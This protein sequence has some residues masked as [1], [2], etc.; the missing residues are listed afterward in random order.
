[1]SADLIPFPKW[2]QGK[3]LYICT[4]CKNPFQWREGESTWYGK[5]DDSIN[6]MQAIICS[7]K[8]RMEWAEING[9]PITPDPLES[10]P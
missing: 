1:M 6:E 9:T 7:Q 2:E 4:Q 8:C 5:M 3:K 10:V